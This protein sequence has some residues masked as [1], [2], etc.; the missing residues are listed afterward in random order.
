MSVEIV[1]KSENELLFWKYWDEVVKNESWA[2]FPNNIKIYSI[3]CRDK[4]IADKSFVYLVNDVPLAAAY[5]PIEKIDGHASIS[6]N[7]GF[8]PAPIFNQSVEKEVLD[9]IDEIAR[10][11]NVKKIM[12]A[13][14]PLARAPYNYL[15][16]YRYLDASILSYVIDLR[17]TDLFAA[18]RRNHR[19]NIKRVLENKD[20]SVFYL[21][22]DNPS[23]EIHEEYRALHHACSGRVTRPIE[24]FNLQFEELKQNK[25]VLFGLRYKNKNIAF[26]YFEYNAD[27]AVT[28]SAADDPE[29]DSLPLYHVLIY[30]AMNYLKE[31]GVRYIDTGQPS[32]P[33]AQFCYNLD[34]KQLDIALFKKG[35]GGDYVNY[36]R[37]VKYFS[38]DEFERDMDIFIKQYFESISYV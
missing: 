27:K 23:Y 12:F 37:G 8:V 19:R 36:Y 24:T 5:L 2:Y 38:K 13:I 30:S 31:R 15:G 21:D 34:K 6:V 10:Q 11:Q 29:F 18:C 1:Y 20:F 3:I 16:Q 9:L 32:S 33:S 14:D 7:S 26:H 17:I 25:A 22:K 28:Y 4:I 35:F